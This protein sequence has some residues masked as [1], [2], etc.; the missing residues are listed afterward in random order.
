MGVAGTGKSTIGELVAAD[1]GVELIEGDSYHPPANVE[2]MSS[3]HPLTDEDRRPWLETLAGLVAERRAAGRTAVL[4]C[5]ALRRAYRDILRGDIPSDEVFFVHL[6][7][8][9]DVLDARMRTREHF[10]PAALLQSQ[11]DTLEPLEPDETGVVVDV[12]L[13]VDEVM[14]RVREAI[15]AWR[16]ARG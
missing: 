3:G 15:D 10:M 11:F 5:S 13:P 9:F 1:L 8:D 14:D 7:A 12:A 6:H 16:S 2:K 4:A